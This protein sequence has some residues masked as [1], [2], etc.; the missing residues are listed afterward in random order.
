MAAM[1]ITI[2]YL[3]GRSK[4]VGPKYPDEIDLHG[5]LFRLAERGIATVTFA[6]ANPLT[7][8]LKLRADGEKP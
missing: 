4:V 1:W 3:D 5:M 7:E 6:H 2:D 8:L